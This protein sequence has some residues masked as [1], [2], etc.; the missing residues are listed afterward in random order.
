VLAKD[1]FLKG[2]TGSV[3]RQDPWKPLAEISAAILALKLAGFQFENTMPQAPVLMP[4]SPLVSA[5]V[6]Q[7]LAA[8][9]RT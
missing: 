7:P 8:A 4:H 1:H 3:A 6:A 5:F 2:F 9:V